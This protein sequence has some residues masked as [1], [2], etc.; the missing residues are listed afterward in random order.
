MARQYVAKDDEAVYVFK[1]DVS[2]GMNT[3]QQASIISEN[4][5]TLLQNILLE[6]AGQTTLRTG[7]TRIDASYPSGA[8]SGYGLFGFNPD[9]GVFSLMAMQGGVL[10]GW[11]SAGS[12]SSKITGFTDGIPST[13]IKAGQQT[14]LDVLL[15]ANGTD[16]SLQYLYN[17]K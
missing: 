15:I 13:M 16:N 3:R 8:A 10:S 11:P 4:Q 6:T 17:V 9:G 1:R 2:G 12:F 7:Q 14:Q 5:A